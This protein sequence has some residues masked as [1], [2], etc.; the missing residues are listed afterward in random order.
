[1]REE[2]RRVH[3]TAKQW[4]SDNRLA[5]SIVR[6]AAEGDL[7]RLHGAVLSALERHDGGHVITNVFMPALRIAEVVYGN[8]CR[9]V[10]AEAIRAQITSGA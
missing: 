7:V 8:R 6:G 10:V 2:D 1:V 3:Q 5:V 4:P 9:D